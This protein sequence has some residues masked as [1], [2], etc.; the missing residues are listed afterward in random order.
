METSRK[1][2]ARRRRTVQ[3]MDN[4]AVAYLR[5]STQDQAKYGVSLDAQRSSIQAFA[6]ARGLTIASWHVE[7]GVS[8]SVAPEERPALGAALAELATGPA[9]TLLFMRVDRVGRDSYDLLGL[10]RRAK[11]EGWTLAACDGTVDITTPQGE[12]MFTTQAAFAQLEREM[13]RQRTREGM[14]EKRAQ[15]VHVGRPTEL[16]ED[17]VRRI[18]AERQAGS[19]WSAIA[20]ALNAEGITTARGKSWLPNGVRQVFHGTAA[21]RILAELGG[22]LEDAA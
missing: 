17:A 13:I 20:R 12:A 10:V 7:E 15:G 3:R 8:G 2:R 21:A 6:A 4:L 16:S 9:K 11:G 14:A 1:T 19:G 5:V 18:V 22:T